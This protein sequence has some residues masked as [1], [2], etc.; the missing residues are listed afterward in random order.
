VSL[1]TKG[2]AQEQSLKSAGEEKWEERRRG[3][4]STLTKL[5]SDLL[6]IHSSIRMLL[7]SL[8][9][10]LL[11][12]FAFSTIRSLI[13]LFQHLH[14]SAPLL[15]LPNDPSHQNFTHHL[16]LSLSIF[17]PFLSHSLLPFQLLFS[18]ALV[19]FLLLVPIYFF[20]TQRILLSLASSRIYSP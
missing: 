5:Y 4:S 18:A 8:T 3:K 20:Y 16:S 2:K 10:W 12:A 1:G 19:V 17:R 14:S 6:L 9:P 11:H 15:F 13:R 7:G